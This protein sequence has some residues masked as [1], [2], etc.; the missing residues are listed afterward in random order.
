MT[1][2]ATALEQWLQQQ[3]GKDS[4]LDVGQAMAIAT[5]A[6]QS[7]IRQYA[8]ERNDNGE[9][10][11]NEWGQALKTMQRLQRDACK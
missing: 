10:P 11:C 4:L 1:E 7:E 2:I 3:P 6:L 8:T 5:L 9:N